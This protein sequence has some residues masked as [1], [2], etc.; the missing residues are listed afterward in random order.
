MSKILF[1]HPMAESIFGRQS[2]PIALTSTLL[3]GEGHECDIFDTTFLNTSQMLEVNSQ[4]SSDK[5]VELR[6]F[7]KYDEK[8]VEIK[9]AMNYGGYKSTV[10]NPEDN[11]ITGLMIRRALRH[12]S[13]H[14]AQECNNGKLLN[15]A[16]KEKRKISAQK[17]IAFKSSS[18]LTGSVEK[19][20]EAYLIEDQP[21]KVISNLRKFCF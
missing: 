8:K 5:Q 4:H 6:Q 13:V 3:N 16:K 21:R 2:I 15:I 17:V 1:I 12:E 14:I 11:F 10:D 20:Y 19:E 18:K 7:K 9:N